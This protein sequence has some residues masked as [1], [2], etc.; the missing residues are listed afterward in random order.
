M[1]LKARKFDVGRAVQLYENHE[2]TRYREH[3]A[4]FD[5][6]VEPLKGELATGK[7]TVLVSNLSMFDTE[8]ILLISFRFMSY[9]SNRDASGASIVMFTA[10][11]HSP[12]QSC[13]KVTLQAMVYQLDIAMDDVKTQ[14]SGI[15]FIYNMSQSKYSNF[16]YELSQKILSLLKG[17]YP[18]RLKKVLIVMAPLWFKAP[19]KILRLFVREKLRDR[20][21]M[22][23]VSQISH[24]I[25]LSSLPVELGGSVKHDH[26][27]WL[28]Y[29]ASR[30]AEVTSDVG[31]LTDLASYNKFPLTSGCLRN[32]SSGIGVIHFSD[33]SGQRCSDDE[34]LSS[35]SSTGPD[36]LCSSSPGTTDKEPPNGSSPTKTPLHVTNSCDGVVNRKHK[37]EKIIMPPAPVIGSNGAAVNGSSSTEATRA[38]EIDVPSDLSSDLC[39]QRLKKLEEEYQSRGFIHSDTD[40]GMTIEEFI[41]YMRQKGRKGLIE[42]YND[43]KH[44]VAEPSFEASRMRENQYKNRYTDVLCG[45][46]SRVKLPIVNGDACSDYINAN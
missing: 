12:I 37:P 18:A 6:T 7:F 35:A 8:S 30:T 42:E 23:G 43:V 36:L 29:C 14:R 3:L 10:S 1:V 33:S 28:Q 45:D 20:V 40:P 38:N 5:P 4:R 32:G 19:F 46:I 27:K 34:E 13:H 21:F 15:V 44:R 25:P 22:V 39:N 24:H 9:Q 41:A 31:G 2:I 26:Q 16:D 11:K 17:A